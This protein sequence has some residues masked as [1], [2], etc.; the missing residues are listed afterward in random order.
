M[1]QG[2]NETIREKCQVDP[3]RPVLLGVS[4]GPDS[5]FMLDTLQQLGYHLIIAHLDH[6]LRPESSQEAEGIQQIA[7]ELNIHLVMKTCDVKGYA[8][9]HKLSI[10]QAARQVRYEFLFDQARTLDVQAVAVAHTADDQI[11]T[12][13]LHLLRGTGLSGLT[14]MQHRSLPNAW[15][16]TIPLIRPILDIYRSQIMAYLQTRPYQPFQDMSNWDTA[17]L[18]NHI[19]HELLPIL[20]NYNPR[21][22]QNIHQLTAILSEE[23]RIMQKVTSEAWEHC[24]HSQGKGYLQFNKT[25]FLNQPLAI[26]RRMIRRAFS[27]M[28]SGLSDVEFNH[29]EQAI[30][31]FQK[32]SES[33]F[34]Q[35]AASLS[36]YAEYDSIFIFDQSAEL[37]TDDWPR[38]TAPMLIDLDSSGSIQLNGPWNLHY[39]VLENSPGIYQAALANSDPYQA[40]L[41][42]DQLELPLRLRCRQSGDRFRPFGLAGRQIK[43]S[44]FMINHKLP[45]RARSSWPLVVSQNEI[46]WI[47]GFQIAYAARLTPQ[48]Q[49]ILH[50]HLV[51][52]P[53]LTH[54]KSSIH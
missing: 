4:G 39:S 27:V 54:S 12:V 1:F 36:I 41:D 7:G 40:W 45:Q 49:R 5:I 33:G 35:L 2:I 10:E 23:E 11:E 52:R 38:L 30:Q 21:L 29:I 47:P 53:D 44:D 50:L 20:E 22:R 48:T 16:Q 18:R 32:P 8:L 51:S 9:A 19:R 43:L 25:A 24:L 34:S 15:S 3:L 28:L 37:P 17:Y 42:F 26:Q 14:G 31:F 6:Q 46:I 13:L